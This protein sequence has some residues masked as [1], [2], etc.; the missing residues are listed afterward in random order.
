M[1]FLLGREEGMI[2]K[3]TKRIEGKVGLRSV[4]N[5]DIQLKDCFIPESLRLT[6]ATSWATGPAQCLFYTRL[7][8]A[9]I[10]VGC[11]MGAYE[12]A[13]DYA[14]SRKQFGKPLASF[15]IIQEKLV[16]ALAIIQAQMLFC[17]HVSREYDAERLTFGQAS[18]CK[19]QATLPLRDAVRLCREVMGGNGMIGDFIAARHMMDIE[20]IYS[21][22]GTYDI[23][24]LFVFTFSFFSFDSQD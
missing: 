16:R 11:A 6:N 15:Q 5:V 10:A 14:L 24:S 4:Q 19:A 3:E 8:A 23:N 18:F 7:I 17:L 2:G 12:A 22:E 13:L 21:Y 1:G 9:W 20:A